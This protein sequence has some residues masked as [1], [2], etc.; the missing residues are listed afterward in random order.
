MKN[1]RLLF[2]TLIFS[3]ILLGSCGSTEEKLPI[4]TSDNIVLDRPAVPG[5][6]SGKENP[7]ST[8]E[9]ASESGQKLYTK[10]CANCHGKEGAGDGPSSP[11][12]DPKP[13]NLTSTQPNLM[14]DYLFWRISEG[15]SMEPF[16]S[17]MPPWK[18][19]LN[20]EDIWQII[21][22]IRSLE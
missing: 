6:Y 5:D 2:F 17:S 18:S 9:A 12:L 3:S 1:G 22:Y 10:Y 16:K 20:E 21:T 14:D 13:Q 8:D 4:V 11:S 15:G 7:Y 19:V